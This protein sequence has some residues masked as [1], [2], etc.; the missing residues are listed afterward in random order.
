M[1]FK[2][3]KNV[4]NF[5]KL[6]LYEETNLSLILISVATMKVK[7]SGDFRRVRKNQ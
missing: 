7:K 6:S 1:R 2:R 3:I 4:G 5:L